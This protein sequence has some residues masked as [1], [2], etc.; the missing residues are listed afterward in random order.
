MNLVRRG[1]A[2][3]LSTRPLNMQRFSLP[4]LVMASGS[5]MMN[6]VSVVSGHRELISTWIGFSIAILGLVLIVRLLVV[7]VRERL[8]SVNFASTHTKVV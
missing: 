4:V 7:L 8:R 5:A 6:G 2:R 3:L 1:F